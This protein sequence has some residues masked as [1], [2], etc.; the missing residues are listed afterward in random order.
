[1][2]GDAMALFNSMRVDF[3]PALHS[4]RHLQQTWA[5]RQQACKGLF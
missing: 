1:M 5:A 2:Q 3:W 4:A